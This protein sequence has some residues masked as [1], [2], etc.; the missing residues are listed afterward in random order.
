MK[1]LFT[2]A[3][4]R[5]YLL[6]YAL[7]LR[8]EFPDLQVFASDASA[9][10]AALWV[11]DDVTPILTPLVSSGERAYINALL[12]EC[13]RH[14]INAVIPLMDFEIPALARNVERFRAEGVALWVSSP[15]VVEACLD[16]RRFYD[17]CV[18][19]GLPTP[20]SWFEDVPAEF[21]VPVV[22]KRVLGSG[23]VGL[24][25]FEA[26]AEVPRFDPDF[27]YQ[28]RIQGQEYGMDVL[29]GL[30][31]RFLH[32]CAR[33]KLLMRAGETDK[34]I[35][36][37]GAD[38]IELGKFIADRLGHV[39]N[40]DLDY[41]E[42]TSGD[43]YFIDFNPRFG[44]GYPFTHASGFDYLRRMVE[45]TLG[46]LPRPFGTGMSILGMKGIELF[47]R[48]VT[49]IEAFEKAAAAQGSGRQ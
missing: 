37:P 27:M 22:R 25:F 9:A 28:E 41:L 3:G 26:G 21:D 1:I 10:T 19:R 14:A 49:A 40:L 47:S 30:D 34:A 8:N 5:S 20:K 16:K 17:L 43:R 31:G 23:S 7:D 4:R 18:A 42:T 44:G 2:N 35:S 29:C 48:E 6:K 13:T 11:S 39:G 38:A 32:A 24:Q 33:K 36:L 15:D 12:A 46:R 45:L